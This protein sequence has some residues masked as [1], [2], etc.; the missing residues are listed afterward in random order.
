MLLHNKELDWR[1]VKSRTG[2]IVFS[3][4]CYKDREL[5]KQLSCWFADWWPIVWFVSIPQESFGGLLGRKWVP[6]SG[7]HPI[8]HFLATRL[9][10]FKDSLPNFRCKRAAAERR[11]F[12]TAWPVIT[13]SKLCSLGQQSFKT[14]SIT[15]DLY[16]L[17]LHAGPKGLEEQNILALIYW[18]KEKSTKVGDWEAIQLC[19]TYSWILVATC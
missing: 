18:P 9:A 7:R 8:A 2:L 5:S 17:L 19:S 15:I 3:L 6:S 1:F 11:H 4:T 12:Q 14:N 16:S 13:N 10:V